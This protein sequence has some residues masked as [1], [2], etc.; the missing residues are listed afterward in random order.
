MASLPCP[1]LLQKRSW[2]S[3]GF[4]CFFLG[5]PG[6]RERAPEVQALPA[7]AV[8]PIGAPAPPPVIEALKSKVSAIQGDDPTADDTDL[9][10]FGDMVGE[11]RLVGLG[12]ATHGTREFF[13]M[14]HR[15]FRYLVEKKGFR[16]LAM[17][18]DGAAACDL[19]RYLQTGEG[20]PEEGLRALGFWTW[21]TEEV[22]GLLS[23]M[24]AY[25][26]GVDDSGKLRFQGIDMQNSLSA[27]RRV[28]A[29][30]RQADPAAAR[31]AETAYGCLGDLDRP[32]VLPDP[33]SQR[34][35]DEQLSCAAALEGVHRKILANRARY[36]VVASS[37]YSCALL[38]ARLM[39]QSEVLFRHIFLRDR[40]L[41]DNLLALF[42]EGKDTKIAVWAHNGHIA[43]LPGAMGARLRKNLGAGYRPVAL[44]FF[45]G[46][47]R[48]KDPESRKVVSIP[49]GPPA[50]DSFE[51]AFHRVG[52][53]SFLFDLRGI[54]GGESW[55]GQR[56]PL[57]D[58]GGTWIPQRPASRIQLPKAFDLLIYLDS[59]QP[60]VPLA[61]RTH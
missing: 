18:A 20:D 43:N 42:E 10:A 29:F 23:W 36:E 34:P 11:A 27:S 54:A 46:T 37:E 41:V 16:I 1:S 17:E 4:L 12:E 5:L 21:N 45:E 60:S 57:W 48:A 56:H 49:S 32:R 19:D 6:C 38:S 33:Y 7:L 2:L 26:E 53:P 50:E 28:L 3:A 35:L 24:R 15:L 8:D 44:T 47:F 58:V 30:L 14:K 61:D 39:V 22:L 55:W 52:V 40:F 13:R 9:H 31:E 59:T 25:N 51:T